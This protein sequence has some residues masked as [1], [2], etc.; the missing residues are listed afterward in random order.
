MQCSDASVAKFQFT[1]LTTFTGYGT[2]SF[3]RNTMTFVY[4]LGYAEA[5]PYLSL[6]DGKKLI[7]TGVDLALGDI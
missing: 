6:P 4:G 3:G 2:G 7:H 1:R 5:V